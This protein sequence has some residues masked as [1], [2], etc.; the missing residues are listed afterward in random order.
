MRK[1]HFITAL[2]FGLYPAHGE[3][4]HHMDSPGGIPM[5]REA[6]GTSWQP[7]STPMYAHHSMNGDWMLMT[8]YNAFLAYDW[9]SGDRGDDQ[10]N[11]TNWFM[12][13]ASHPLAGGQLTLRTMLS[14]EPLTTTSR[15]YPLLFQSGEAY[16][17]EALVDRQHPHDFFMELAASYSHPIGDDAA[18]SLYLA[19]SGEPALGPPAF[20]HRASAADNPAAPISHHWLDS[21]HISFGVATLGVSVDKFR[22]EGSAFNG[23][24]PDEDRW[25]IDGLRLD[26]YAGRIS[27]NPCERWSFQVSHGYLDSPEELHPEEHVWR[28]TASAI[29]NQPLDDGGNW[30]TTLAW[31]L[32][33]QSKL[34]S[35]ALLLESNWNIANRNSLFGRLEYVQKTGEDL[36]LPPDDRKYGITALTIGATHELTSHQPYSVAVGSALTYNFTPDTLHEEYGDHPFGFWLFLRIRPSAMG[37]SMDHSAMETK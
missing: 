20:M 36:V 29:Y 34:D 7:D 18:V 23:R 8:H 14:L 33:H 4:M 37:H 27:Y 2:L 19:P 1:P 13:M 31:G 12:L 6:S 30:A 28:S 26:S 32:N 5:T 15:G 16:H 24:E 22:I 17:G 11:S 10:F 3:M 21:T 9:Q 35:H 25:D